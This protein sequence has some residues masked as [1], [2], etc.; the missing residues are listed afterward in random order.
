M[1]LSYQ[2]VLFGQVFDYW[3]LEQRNEVE[4]SSFYKIFNS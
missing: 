2:K 3:D 1:Q 4:C